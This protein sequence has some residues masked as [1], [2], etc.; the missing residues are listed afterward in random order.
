VRAH[1]LELAGE[2]E[3]AAAEYREAARRTTSLPERRYLE[4]KASS[5]RRTRS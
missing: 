1:L 4:A 3:Q 5:S 2:P